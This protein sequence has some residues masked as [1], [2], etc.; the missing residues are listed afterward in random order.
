MQQAGR[1]ASITAPANPY[2]HMQYCNPKN[3]PNLTI[4]Y[5]HSCRVYAILFPSSQLSG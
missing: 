4:V 3:Y 5:C 1:G 2:G